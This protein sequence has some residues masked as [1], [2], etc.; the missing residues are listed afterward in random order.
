MIFWSNNGGKQPSSIRNLAAPFLYITPLL[1]KH[2]TKITNNCKPPVSNIISFERTL[3][4]LNGSVR[5]S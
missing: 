4:G 3:S 1:I 5:N 2:S